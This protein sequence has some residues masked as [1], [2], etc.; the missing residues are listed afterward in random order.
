V[1]Y[2]WTRGFAEP[3]EACAWRRGE[4]LETNWALEHLRSGVQ[5]PAVARQRLPIPHP[6]LADH[7]LDGRLHCVTATLE[8]L[9][10]TA[11]GGGLE[12]AG[13]G[14]RGA[15][16]TQLRALLLLGALPGVGKR[17]GHF[18][19][20]TS[21]ARRVSTA[22]RQQR[23][24]RAVEAAAGMAAGGGARA[25]AARQLVADEV[26]P[27]EQRAPTISTVGVYLRWVGPMCAP[28][29]R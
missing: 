23:R 18:E 3:A 11:V 28:R 20:E 6:L 22:V 15:P 12:G 2:V 8:P 9:E 17:E 14:S 25:K 19:R 26:R 4:R 1:E 16:P 5:F 24:S 21:A 10:L 7:L 13:W 29:S 27:A